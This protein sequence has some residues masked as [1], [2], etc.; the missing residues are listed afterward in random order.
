MQVESCLAP[1]QPWPSRTEES[2]IKEELFIRQVLADVVGR[3]EFVS[4]TAQ[5][6]PTSHT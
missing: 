2:K 4:P 3:V 6:L 5:A 1:E